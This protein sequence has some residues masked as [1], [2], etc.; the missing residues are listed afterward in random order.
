[1]FALHVKAIGSR[2]RLVLS[3]LVL[4]AFTALLA[5]PRPTFAVAPSPG[6]VTGSGM[7]LGQGRVLLQGS[8]AP[9]GSNI[10]D[11][12]FEYGTNVSYGSSVTCAQSVGGE[13]EPVAV[14][15]AVEGLLAGTTYHF[16]LVAT[17]EG[18]T[19]AGED[20]TFATPPLPS[21]AMA[22]PSVLSYNLQPST[23]V[24]LEGDIGP[25]GSTVGDC[26]FEYGSSSSFGSASPCTAPTGW[27]S[28]AVHVY[29]FANAL[30]W[31][32]LYYARLVAATT[33]GTT[34][35]NTVTFQTPAPLLVGTPDPPVTSHYPPYIPPPRSPW[36]RP[37]PTA[38]CDALTGAK[39]TRCIANVL[40]PYR[41][42][43]ADAGLYVAFCPGRAGSS[44][45][46]ARAA[47]TSEAGWPAKEC[48]KMD[49]GPA[50]KHHTIV[51]EKGVHNWLLGGYGSD[52]II[53]GNIGDVI[54]GDYH[55]SGE[56]KH[57][58]AIIHAGNGRNV[59]YA[60][61]TLDYVWTGSNPKTIVHAH[62]SGISG[63]IHCGSSQQVMFLSNVSE[64]HFTLIGC[65]RISH[66]S[67]GY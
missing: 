32:T 40:H 9:Q 48:L 5:C 24:T 52:T 3:A 13:S 14:S 6:V 61:D 30:P 46:R 2:P 25:N 37:A 57:Q 49:K 63:V 34:Y 50:G 26:H 7:L 41:R 45:I 65:G 58:T 18:G 35:G 28:S 31:G 64:K 44:S 21:V 56:P 12:H 47:G 8:V 4:L 51:G 33:A 29:G 55:P 42:R 66:Y 15:A 23:S 39:R 27:A 22:V 54:W 36:K 16:R 17:N 53:G 60:N 43:A 59:I 10:S 62:G 11:C 38:R 20:V 1:V 67:V 19:N